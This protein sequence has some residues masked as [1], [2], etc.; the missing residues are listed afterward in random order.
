VGT[1]L[2]THPDFG[3]KVASELARVTGL[4]LRSADNKFAA[5]AAHDALVGAHGTLK[6]LATAL[7]KIT[8]DIRWLASGA[9]L[10]TR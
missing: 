3:R 5:L 10:R 6:T 9:A 2:N 1:G 8:N 4:P 7:M